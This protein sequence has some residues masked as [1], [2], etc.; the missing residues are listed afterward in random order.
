[1]RVA[2]PGALIVCETG[3]ASAAFVLK[4]TKRFV[5]SIGRLGGEAWRELGEASKSGD[6][7]EI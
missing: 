5:R 1:M 4:G 6:E 2:E 7:E 3:K